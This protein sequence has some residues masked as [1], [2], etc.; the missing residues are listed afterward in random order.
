MKNY[1]VSMF[2][3][4]NGERN[5]TGGYTLGATSA[6]NAVIKMIQGISGSFSG[7]FKGTKH[8]GEYRDGDMMVRV[9]P[10]R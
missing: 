4:V 5:Y 7:V 3:D 2:S 8:Y 6:L 1:Y 9:V 10:A